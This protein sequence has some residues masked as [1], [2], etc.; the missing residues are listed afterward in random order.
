[1]GRS[2]KT[3]G[4]GDRVSYAVLVALLNYTTWYTSAIVNPGPFLTFYQ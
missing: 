3:A 4:I 2:E 1:M